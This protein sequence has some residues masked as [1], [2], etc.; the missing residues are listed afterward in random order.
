M[1]MNRVL[2]PLSALLRSEVKAS[3][4]DVECDV[5]STKYLALLSRSCSNFWYETFSFV[6]ANV[7]VRRE[8]AAVSHVIL[9]MFAR[10]EDCK[11][12]CRR[13]LF[14]EPRCSDSEL[15]H[16]QVVPAGVE[17]TSN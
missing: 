7:V 9:Y 16:H 1:V 8:A 5:N 15:V 11:S 2:L 14:F 4:V 13:E 17:P 3:G 12:N 10:F 6:S